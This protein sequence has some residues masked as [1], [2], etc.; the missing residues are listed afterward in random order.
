MLEQ[1]NSDG[2]M[3]QVTCVGRN[4]GEFLPLE[5]ME[6]D[7]Y[8]TLGQQLGSMVQMQKG[9]TCQDVYKWV[10]HRKRHKPA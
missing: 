4:T 7:Q 3:N 2:G 6:R 8:L 5:M 9:T 1:P 10:C